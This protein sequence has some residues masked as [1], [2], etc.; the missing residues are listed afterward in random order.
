VTDTEIAEEIKRALRNLTR[1]TIIIYVVL[2][3]LGLFAWIDSSNQRAEIKQVAISTNQA[4]CALRF[5]LEARVENAEQ[6]LVNNPDGIPGLSA[7]SI[8]TSIESQRR[9]I[10]A[11]RGLDCG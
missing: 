7:A 4:L 5:D 2:A 8:Q 3:G 10:V 1:A 11:L 6:F 9:T